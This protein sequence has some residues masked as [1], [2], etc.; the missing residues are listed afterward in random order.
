MK[1]LPVTRVH[2]VARVTQRPDESCA[3]YRDVLGFREIQRPGF[4]FRGAWLF[5]YGLQIHIIQNDGRSPD[6]SN[7][8][9]T[10]FNHLAL[11]VEDLDEAKN[12]LRQNG[13][14]YREQVNAGGIHQVFFHDP[15]GHVIE[16]AEYGPTPPEKTS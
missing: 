2:H 9:D 4:D 10:R 5:N 7:E 3:F 8:I 15:D 11:E 14:I 13:I 12:R 1:T 16:I 6:P